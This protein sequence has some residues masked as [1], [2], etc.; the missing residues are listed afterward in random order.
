MTISCDQRSEQETRHTRETQRCLVL[1]RDNVL[2]FP[3]MK[4]AGTSGLNV[5][6]CVFRMPAFLTTD[7]ERKRRVSQGFLCISHD[8]VV[9]GLRLCDSPVFVAHDLHFPERHAAQ[10]QPEL[11]VK[12][13]VA[14]GSPAML[15]F[16]VVVGLRE[17]VCE[18]K[19][20]PL[21]VQCAFAE[22]GWRV[23]RCGCECV[24]GGA[25]ARGRVCVQVHLENCCLTPP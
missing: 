6:K 4:H 12:A 21:G 16:A 9:A 11:A 1:F 22:S 19:S 23:C 7:L 17:R 3:I 14:L 2:V 10:Q 18:I 8:R 24:C 25:C 5:R 15:A 20:V 13:A